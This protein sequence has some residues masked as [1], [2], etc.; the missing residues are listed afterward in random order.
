MVELHLAVQ[1]H[2]SR[3]EPL[4]QP[5]SAAEVPGPRRGG[6]AV[7]RI[8]G[9][10]DRF[11]VVEQEGKVYSFVPSRDVE[12]ADLV[13]DLARQVKS[14]QP[15]KVV[16]KFAKERERSAGWRRILEQTTGALLRQTDQA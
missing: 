3:L 13:L 8:V 1:P 15:G 2:G 16:R 14:C 7:G 5:V 10:G 9:E 11:F 12:K 4:G 6:K